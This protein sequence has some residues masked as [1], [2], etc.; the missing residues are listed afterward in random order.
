[1]RKLAWIAP[2]VVALE[3]LSKALMRRGMPQRLAV[4]PG[5]LALTYTENTGMAFS[6]LS[7]QSWLLGVL[8]ALAI[9]LGWVILRRYQLGRLAMTGAMLMLGGAVG[10]MLDR[11]LRGYVVDMFELLFVR[12]AVFNVADVA[13]TVG[14]VL[15]GASLLFC[16]P[17]WREKHGNTEGAG[18]DGGPQNGRHSG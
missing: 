13:L 2:A 7:G 5:V 10:N 17:D 3:Q 15:L 8:S 1:M 9:V 6:L 16:P 4:W 11:L 18:T 14:C 12:F